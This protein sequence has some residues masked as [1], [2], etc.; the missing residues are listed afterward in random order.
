MLSIALL[1]DLQDPPVVADTV[2]V[3]DHALV[4]NDP[5]WEQPLFPNTKVGRAGGDQGPGHPVLQPA[6]TRSMEPVL[7]PGSSFPLLRL[8]GIATMAT[9]SQYLRGSTSPSTT[10]AF[11][12]PRTRGECLRAVPHRA[13]KYPVPPI[14]RSVLFDDKLDLVRRSSPPR[15]RATTLIDLSLRSFRLIAVAKTPGFRSLIPSDSAASQLDRPA[16]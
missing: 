13:A 7:G 14:G 8:Y 9:A 4:A 5:G 16:R 2:V 3:A 11:R 1:G 6:S 15:C 10:G 12:S